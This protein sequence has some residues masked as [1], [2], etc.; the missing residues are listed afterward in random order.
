METLRGAA[1]LDRARIEA[2]QLQRLRPLLAYAYE[3][4]AYYRRLFD[5]VG[6]LPRHVAVLSDLQRIPITSRET[7]Q[8]L[9]PDELVSRRM[10]RGKLSVSRTSGSTGAPLRL[11]R[12]RRESWFRLLLTLRAFRF[13]GLQ[14]NDRVVT[15]SRLP[16]T[17][18]R[19][20]APRMAPFLQRRNISFF[21]DIEK[22][23]DSI[24]RFDPTVLYGYAPNVASLGELYARRGLTARGLRL[25][26]TSAET[27]TAEYRAMIQAGFGVAPIDIYNCTELGDIAWQCRQRSGF[28]INSD[29][30]LF[31]I[32]QPPAEVI[33]PAG[34][35]E[36]VVTHLYRYAMPLIRYSPGDFASLSTAVCPCGIALPLLDRLD[37]RAQT[38][39]SLPG[40]RSFI[41]FSRIMSEFPEIARYQVVQRALD[42][43][44]VNVVPSASWSDEL[45]RRIAAALGSK[46]GFAIKIEVNAVTPS[47]LISGAGKFRPVIPL[48]ASKDSQ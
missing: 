15:I 7:L 17:P 41:G 20:A 21:D 34:M 25:V 33:A 14:W 1:F 43:F 27:L 29:W 3:N 42:H 4:V 22:H 26:A 38:R 31:E 47:Q 39:V 16:S 44:I 30:L 13:N 35:G 37:G 32:A 40:G 10:R 5:S 11:Y 28:H 48:S 45:P 18:I 23:L 2:L 12:R 9:G 6:F 24:E 36:V 8:G 46:M 19:C